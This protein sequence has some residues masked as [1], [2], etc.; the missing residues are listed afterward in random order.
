MVQVKYVEDILQ[1]IWSDMVTL[2]RPYVYLSRP[3]HFKFFKDCLLEILL[4]SFLNPLTH[5]WL[6][7]NPC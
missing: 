2:G 6:T 4:G 5:I 1:K 7:E 3:Y